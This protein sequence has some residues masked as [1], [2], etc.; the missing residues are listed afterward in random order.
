MTQ[1]AVQWMIQELES[2]GI[3]IDDATKIIALNKEHDQT[4][5]FLEE[6]SYNRWYA[7]HKIPN[8][9]EWITEG[10][11][12]EKKYVKV[13]KTTDQLLKEYFYKN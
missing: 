1:T 8:R 4:K 11:Y 10:S 2:K 12:C 7:L 3:Q 6:I 13:I 9:Y 5:V